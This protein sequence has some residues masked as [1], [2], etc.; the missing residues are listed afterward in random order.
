MQTHCPSDMDDPSCAWP[1]WKFDMKRE[2]LFTKLHVQYNTYPSPIQDPDAFH[3][4]IFEISHKADSAAEF[5]H[6]ARDRK[7]QRLRELND[8]LESASFEIIANPRLISTPQWQHAVQLFRTKSLDS[9]VRYFASY[10]PTDHLWHPLCHA[11]AP[12]TSNNELT[13]YILDEECKRIRTY[14]SGG[15]RCRPSPLS[16]IP[17]PDLSDAPARYRHVERNGPANAVAPAVTFSFS[18]PSLRRFPSQESRSPIGRGEEMM[19]PGNNMS[20]MPGSG[21]LETE[22]GGN[23]AIS[24][25]GVKDAHHSIQSTE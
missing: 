4:D 19:Q 14:D 21:A 15:S 22:E 13:P 25:K 3:H 6:L 8:A 16:S 7:Q 20:I 11:S 18:E 9:L 12:I 24:N 1:A 17:L 23:E 2:D 5:H 10:L